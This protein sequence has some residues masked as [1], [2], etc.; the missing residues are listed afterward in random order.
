MPIVITFDARG[1]Q[2]DEHNRI[3]SFFERL[4]WQNLGGSSYRYPALGSE[5]P[6]EDWFNHVIP[7]LMLLRAY[8]RWATQHGRGLNKF[9]IDVQTSTGCRPD[10]FGTLPQAGDAIT[11][12][13]PTNQAFGERVLRD[14]IETVHWPY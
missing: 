4:G 7:A 2:P 5:H 11:L 12:Y 13:P 14:W 1:A 6:T 9:T 10:G 8:S 3:Q